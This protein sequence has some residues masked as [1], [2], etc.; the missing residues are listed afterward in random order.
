MYYT[1]QDDDDLQSI[2]YVYHEYAAAAHTIDKEYRIMRETIGTRKETFRLQKFLPDQWGWRMDDTNG[3]KTWSIVRYAGY[4]DV[5]DTQKN[6]IKR[7]TIE[8]VL[9]AIDSSSQA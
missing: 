9:Q 4:F 7:G 3:S 6:V 2:G 5:R 8:E 1:K